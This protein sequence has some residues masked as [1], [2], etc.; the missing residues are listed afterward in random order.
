MSGTED[1]NRGVLQQATREAQERALQN[2]KQYVENRQRAW[3][4]LANIDSESQPARDARARLDKARQDYDAFVATIET[5]DT[6][7]DTDASQ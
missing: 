4:A 7:P 2:L 5:R 3:E 1:S 6:E